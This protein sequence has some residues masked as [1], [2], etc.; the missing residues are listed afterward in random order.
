MAIFLLIAICFYRNK[1][2]NDRVRISKLSAK[3]LI[4]LAAAT[5]AAALLSAGNV[6][7]SKGF[8][9]WMQNYNTV[10]PLEA[11]I[12]NGFYKSLISVF[13]F[14]FGGNYLIPKFRIKPVKES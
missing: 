12:R 5:M 9:E 10:I 6:Y 14:A 2:E 3:Y 8:Q 4:L 1:T 11:I 13:F 7:H